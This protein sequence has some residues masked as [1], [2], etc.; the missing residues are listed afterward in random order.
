MQVFNVATCDPRTRRDDKK[1][2]M[3][4]GSRDPFKTNQERSKYNV[5][6]RLRI[7]LGQVTLKSIWSKA[8]Q[9]ENSLSI[10]VGLSLISFQNIW[11]HFA[12]AIAWDYSLIAKEFFGALRDSE[13]ILKYF[14]DDLR[15]ASRYDGSCPWLL[16]RISIFRSTIYRR[17][18]KK[19]HK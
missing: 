5:N 11:W 10:S 18:I 13:V 1:W 15:R 12:V 17:L 4:V 14:S 9:N 2:E 8:T 16:I 19:K 6:Y 7:G 3:C